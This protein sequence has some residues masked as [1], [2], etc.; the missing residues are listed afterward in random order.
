ME[1]VRKYLNPAQMDVMQVWANKTYIVASRALGKSE[2][3]DAPVLIRN[4]HAM[5]RSTGGLISP[6]YQKAW[7]N[8]L[9]A[10]CKALAEWGYYQDIHYV[11]GKKA[12]KK[13]GFASPRR[14]PLAGGW[15]NCIHFWN[16]TILVVLSFNQGMS[17]NSMSLDWI[18]GPEAKFLDF[19]KIKSEVNPANRGNPEFDYCPWHHSE[20]YTTDMPT[21]GMG[22]WILDKESE[23]DTQHI[24]AIRQTLA[25][26]IKYKS[27]PNP[28]DHDKRMIRE[29]TSD[30]ALMRRF[31]PPK[32]PDDIK[33][34]K[35]KEFTTFFAEYDVFYN[36]EV[37]GEDFVWQMKRDLPP[38][39][40]RTAILNERLFKIA[41]GFYSALEEAIHF[42][43]P[44]DNGQLQKFG[45]NFDL[46]QGAG[47]LGD[48]DLDFRKPLH[49]AFDSNSAINSMVVGQVDKEKRIMYTIN[50]LFVKTPDKMTEL[51]HKFCDYYR[52]FLKKEVVVYY[53]HTFVWTD[54]KSNIRL[55]DVI[56]D[57]L[58]KNSWKYSLVYVGQT[59]THRWKHEQIDL[60]LKG[61]KHL[62]PLF[63]LLTNEYLRLAMFRAGIKQGRNGFEKDKHEEALE[64]SPDNPDQTKTHITD[65][66]DTLWY[67][68]N[69]YFTEAVGG[70]SFMV[71]CT[72]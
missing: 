11:V 48:S 61:D 34:G 69:F 6:T 30:L 24:A 55:I 20:F 57:V 47:C 35:T 28:S 43:I 21:S 1:K 65:A 50:S 63:N 46:I 26:L 54:G 58:K 16:G 25:L 53:D 59:P 64:D 37:L 42:Y 67:G 38:L 32:N 27:K 41:N 52:G 60:S 8:T 15:D 12:P 2:G 14:P 70:G 66:W 72:M 71:V 22:K 62:F 31:Q 17:A 4:V 13:M 10:I 29:L 44:K 36:I 33:K 23:M 40:F 5:P 18:L 51:V 39:V 9:P 19:E 49:V 7:A 68:V 45:G 56:E 3:M